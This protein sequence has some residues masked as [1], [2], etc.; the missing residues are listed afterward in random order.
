LNTNGDFVWA[1]AMGGKGY[2]F[3]HDIAVDTA[4]NV[5]T[6]GYF[7]GATDFDPGPGTFNLSS[8]G[9]HSIFLSKLDTDGNFVWARAMGGWG[10]DEGRDIALDAA[11]NVYV[12]GSFQGAADLD[13]GPGSFT[14]TSTKSY[15][16]F[17]S[18]LD[19]DGNFLWARSVVG[20]QSRNSY[21]TA[22]DAVG[23]V[24]S[25][26]NFFGTVDFDPGPGTFNLTSA[27]IQD[28]FVSKL[29][30]D[31]Q[32]IWARAMGGTSSD[33]SRGIGVDAAGNVYTTGSF[34]DTADF[35]PGPGSFKL[36]PTS[37]ED[38]FVAKLSGSGHIPPSAVTS[39][40]IA[41]H[42]SNVTSLNDASDLVVN[43]N[44]IA[45]TDNTEAPE[46]LTI[47]PSTTGPT[48]ADSL[49]FTVAFD[50]AIV[51]FDDPSDLDISHNGTAH[52]GAAITGGPEVYTVTVEGLSGDG[53]F[54]LAVSTTSDVE[55]LA[56]HPLDLSVTSVPVL[57]DNTAPVFSGLDVS[58]SEASVG[59]EAVLTFASSE[60]LAAPP[61]V[62]VNGNPASASFKS[63]FAFAYTVS[64]LDPLGPA[65]IQINGID[66]AG[67]AGQL[68]DNLSLVIVEAPGLPA[69]W[70]MLAALALLSAGAFALHCRRRRATTM[71]A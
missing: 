53:S 5:Y 16:S 13:P 3:G 54:T 47:V 15:G 8:V 56:G 40:Q 55:D 25:A 24:F 70:P 63:P 49:D 67:N 69:A 22:V 20:N 66:F 39:T 28:I 35:D 7:Q 10:A 6:T 41:V 44:V 36:T 27:G 2:S 45:S 48:N 38:V 4:G 37:R 14:V 26:G 68:N 33:M 57:I 21:H 42:Q 58:P 11:G 43:H 17:V 29:D 52:T 32:F 12:T 71:Q 51:N 23:N 1:R 50:K 30:T 64:P 65:A 9:M 18:K 31:G 61:D 62:L 60:D 19:A 59:Q 34:T 46:I